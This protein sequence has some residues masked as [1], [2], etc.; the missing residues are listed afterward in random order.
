MKGSSSPGC[1]PEAALQGGEQKRGQIAT[2]R[3]FRSGGRGSKGVASQH[4]VNVPRL[5][6]QLAN[7]SKQAFNV[8]LTMYADDVR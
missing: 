8:S 1:Q 3:V 4:P 5:E 2:E 7:L 6:D